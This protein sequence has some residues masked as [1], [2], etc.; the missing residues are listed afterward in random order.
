MARVLVA[1]D[2]PVSLLV[3]RHRL[4]QMGHRVVEAHDGREALAVLNDSPVDL[5]ISDQEMPGLTGLALRNELGDRL[6][7]PFVLLTGWADRSELVD[8]PG[9]D[10]VDVYLTKPVSSAALHDALHGLLDEASRTRSAGDERIG[11]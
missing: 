7:C 6:A 1:D 9:A 3:V 8:L 2:D 10:M 4:E 11:S 5:V